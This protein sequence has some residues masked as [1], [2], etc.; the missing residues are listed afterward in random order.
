MTIKHYY[1]K[2]L[3]QGSYYIES[4][5]KAALIDPW[6]DPKIFLDR[7]LNDRAEIV[8]VFETH[9]HADFISSH[10]E[11][12]DIT[13]AEIY[14]NEKA[15]AAYPHKA[16]GH[17]DEVTVGD[18]TVQA[19]FT[20]GHSPDHN[21]YLLRDDSGKAVAVFTGDALFVGDVGRPDLREGAGHLQTNRR[22]L[23]SQMFDTVHNVFDELPDDVT[24]YPAHG[25]G[26]LCG[27]NMG[28][29]LSSSIGKEKAS[30]W[31]FSDQNREEFIEAFLEGQAFI[32]QYFP[33][34]VEV[35]RCGAPALKEA[36]SSVHKT[37]GASVPEDVTIVDTRDFE[38]F[39]KSHVPGALN[40]RCDAEDKFETWLGALLSPNEAFCLVC[41]SR[42]DADAAVYRAAKIG[43][44]G[45]I[46]SAVINPTGEKSRATEFDLGHFK[47]APEDFTILD[48]RNASEVA[49]GKIFGE[50]AH[51]PLQQLRKR[52]GEL[53]SNKPIAVHCAGG[54]RSAAAYSI[55]AAGTDV[56]VHDIGAAIREFSDDIGVRTEKTPT[57]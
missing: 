56:K 28:D 55:L 43:Y 3:A 39:K 4:K 33:N 41:R 36:V 35:N 9:P 34:S 42:T 49:Q 20:P 2:A 6:R 31:A 29:E 40:I 8:A 19:L 14:I 27:R 23:A 51:I 21:S 10:A 54:Y 7:A 13:G 24:V 15:G 47:R 17:H 53:P 11:I 45:N 44:E 52:A 50:A 1:D 26:S 16:M 25:A 48:V 5:G 22:E 18:F 38:D 57:S 46:V 30:N 32:P 37:M 12:R